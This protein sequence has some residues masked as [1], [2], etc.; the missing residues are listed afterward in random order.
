MSDRSLNNAPRRVIV[1]GSTGSVGV[2]A[3]AVI[4]HLTRS[5]QRPFRVVGLAAGN[6]GRLLA[7]QARRFG[8]PAAALA[9]SSR[10]DAEAVAGCE[11]VFTG[12]DAARQLVEQ[13][14][15]DVVVAAIVGVAGLPA[16]LAALRL[17]RVV[18][19]AN[20]ETLVAAGELAMPMVRRHGGALVPV[21]SEHSAVWQCM[22]GAVGSGQ[23]A[24]GENRQ[25]REERSSATATPS[26][27]TGQAP[28]PEPYCPQPTAFP[29][30]IRRIVLTASGGPFRE[31][32]PEMIASATPE[33]ALNH[34]TWDMGP[35]ISV[36]SATMM[37]K[38]LEVIEA[39]HLFGLSGEKIDVLIH[40]Q[41][42]VHGLVEFADHS[43]VAQMGPPDMRTPIHVALTH[44][45][46]L[47]GCSD[48]LDWTRLSRLDFARPDPLRFPALRLGH[49]VIRMGG[50]AGAVLNAANEV[51]VSAF[52]E[53]RV[54]FGRIVEVVAETLAALEV[55]PITSLEDVM[56]ADAAARRH[57]EALIDAGA[58]DVG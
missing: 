57:A 49:D 34:P 52:L 12:P 13:V 58:V 22:G 37:N 14:E 46:R 29:A 11:R 3:L 19:L 23:W 53:R 50:T 28:Q 6:N 36:D 18:A 40:P 9:S 31:A 39:H 4:E 44:P 26:N 25:S 8:C 56:A 1:L 2:N 41:S 10:G 30:H 33:Q 15:A 51:A 16:T 24:V 43:V 5:G 32:T 55:T 7:E 38:A 17:G 35:K 27:P 42:V 48:R 54:R 47:P 45:E 21:D 20:K